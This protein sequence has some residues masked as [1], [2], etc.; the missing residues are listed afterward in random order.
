MKKQE[1]QWIIGS[2]WGFPL[3]FH[4]A[5]VHSPQAML[6]RGTVGIAPGWALW[7]PSGF[8]LAGFDQGNL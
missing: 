4:T 7:R 5:D 6:Y 8:D 2:A 3:G 1:K